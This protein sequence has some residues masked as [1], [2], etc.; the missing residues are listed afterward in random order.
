MFDE[1]KMRDFGKVILNLGK[2]QN[3]SRSETKGYYRQIILNEQPEL[4]QGAFLISHLIKGPTI[5]EMAGAWDAMMEYDVERISPTISQPSCDIVGTGSDAL[6][7][8]NVSTPAA[9]IASACGVYMAKKGARLVT[10]VSGA[11]D[12]LEEFGVDLDVP[13]ELAQKS[14]EKNSI[15]YLPGEKFL[16][17]GW[18]RLIK[19]MRF[20]TVLN[21]IGPITMPCTTTKSIVI[22]VFAPELC[23]KMVEILNEIGMQSAISIYGMSN[24]HDE[25]L[26][27]DEVSTCG[28]TKV[29]ELKNKRIEGYTLYPEDFG[30]K[31]SKYSDIAT[32]GTLRENALAVL[33]VLKGKDDGP[34]L[35]LFCVNAATVLYITGKVP[36][37]KVGVELAKQSVAEGRAFHQLRELVVSQNTSPHKGLAKLGNLVDTI[38]GKLD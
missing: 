11:S 35:D 4:Q 31:L 23:Q 20:T 10:G 17:S 2:G 36:D 5:T 32:R 30:V 27:I 38:E 8:V 15:G 3:L 13:L 24:D 21:I 14:I 16:Q 19:V 9:L 37:L 28:P 1:D 18:S 33:N 7:T 29:L 22:G 26:G 34:L 6:K 25:T 12:I